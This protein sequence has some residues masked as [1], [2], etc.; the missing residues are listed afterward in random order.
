MKCSLLSTVQALQSLYYSVNP[1]S[2]MTG[3]DFSNG[4]DPCANA[5]KGI[6]CTGPAVTGM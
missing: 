4:A 6:Q 1:V 3:W 2:A 5:W